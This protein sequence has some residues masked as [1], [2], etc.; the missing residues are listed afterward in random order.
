MPTTDDRLSRARLALDGLSV[1]DA[2]G[3]RHFVPGMSE[4]FLALMP[5]PWR[6]TDD[7]EMAIALCEVLARHG[8]VDQDD[9]A[10]TFARRYAA[11]D[12]RGYGS[13]A[14][15]L[16]MQL[17]AGR[18]WREVAPA[19]FSGQGSMGNGSAM[20]VAPL[21]AWFADDIDALTEQAA[22]SAEVTHFNDEGR[23]GA[24]AIALAAAFAWNCRG[25]Y[26]ARGEGSSCD[27]PPRVVGEF[28]QFVYD[29]TPP[30]LVRDGIA[31]AIELPRSSDLS[32]AVGRLGN[33]SRVTCPDTV[34]LCVW[35]A[36]RHLG[37]YA[38]AVRA[39]T[40]AGGDLDTNCAIVGGIVCL[41]APGG[42]IPAEWF[43]ARELLQTAL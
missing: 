37:R 39:T 17:C 10:L 27:Y 7:T 9:L 8:R 19:L 41:S 34:P 24:I 6:Y 30:G 4:Q 28:L 35:L 20:R 21:G 12:K 15:L 31:A 22:L 43:K 25:E 42:G 3:Q 29:R 5:V 40:H 16:L 32:A 33:G 18:P 14:H 26:E 38:E 11:D 23:A 36:A 1:G 13:G 2:V